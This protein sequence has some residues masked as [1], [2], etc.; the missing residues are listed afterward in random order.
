VRDDSRGYVL[1]RPGDPA[2][3]VVADEYRTHWLARVSRLRIS[4][5]GAPIMATAQPAVAPARWPW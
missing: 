1:D 4:A 5:D 3:V 2:G